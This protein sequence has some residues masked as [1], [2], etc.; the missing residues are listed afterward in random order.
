MKMVKAVLI[1]AGL[2]GGYVYSDYALLHSEEFCVVAVAEPDAERRLAFAKRHNIPECMQFESYQALFEKDK[3]ADCAMICTPD[4]L[5]YD[6]V[7]RALEKGYHVLCEKPM[8][9]R[10]EEII[11]MSRMAEKYGRI[12]SICHVLRYSLFFRKL[13]ELLREGRIGDLITIQHMEQVGFWHFAHSF[14]RG[15]WC[16]AEETSPVILQK[17]CHDMDILLWLAE[18][19]C[20][21]VSSFGT[22]S[23]FKRENAPGDAPARCVDGCPHR[24]D[25]AFYAPG[26]YLKHPKAKEDGLVYAVTINTD[27]ESVLQKLEDGPYGRCVFFCDNN[28]ADHQVV[29]LEFE[30]GVTV[31][32]TMSAFTK[33]CARTIHLMGTRGQILGNM[34]LGT[35]EISDFVSGETETIR[36]DTPVGGHSGS[37]AAIMKGFVHLVASGNTKE[38][39]TGADISAESHLIALA[40]E[41]SRISGKTVNMAEFSME[42]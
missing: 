23:L 27:K 39:K 4:N 38:Q 29:N 18:S 14:V 11:K 31:S 19:R 10:K 13:K 24:D 22:L 17:C 40:A 41:Q 15:N 26:F 8:S 28:V 36:L 42:G 30:N 9:P 33:D 7:I 37:D 6:P 2:R 12:L 5:H 20:T 1:G 35:V 21:K 25:C 32:F 16:D 34:E 3:C